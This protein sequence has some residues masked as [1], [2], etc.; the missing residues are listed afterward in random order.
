[1]NSA[2]LLLFLRR[3]PR[4][5]VARALGSAVFYTAKLVL[6]SA[7]AALPVWLMGPPLRAFFAAPEN[8]GRI[9]SLGVPFAISAV[10]FAAVGVLLLFLSQD[11]QALA[12]VRALR[13]RTAG[14]HETKK[15]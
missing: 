13:R 10:V 4:I 11:K 2:L 7:I 9:L 8:A 1:V 3:N 6:F 14:K 15:G 5:A 12:I